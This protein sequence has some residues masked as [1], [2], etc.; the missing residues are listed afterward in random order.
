MNERCEYA[1]VSGVLHLTP[2]Q[3]GDLSDWSLPQISKR[4]NELASVSGAVW[5]IAKPVALLGDVAHF[6]RGLPTRLERSRNKLPHEL[7]NA[8]SHSPLPLAQM[9][10]FH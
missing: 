7:S 9:F 1:N 4:L 3:E 2:P 8:P 10:R 5:S 6:A